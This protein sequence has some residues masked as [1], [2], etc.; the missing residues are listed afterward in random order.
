MLGAKRMIWI[1]V[2]CFEIELYELNYNGDNE[3]KHISTHSKKEKKNY[4]FH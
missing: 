2:V 4:I 1:T 3:I